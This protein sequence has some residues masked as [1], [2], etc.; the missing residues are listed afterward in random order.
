M[1]LAIILLNWRNEARTT[2]AAGEIMAWTAPRPELIVVDNES[3]ERSWATLQ[4]DLPDTE[5]VASSTNRGFAGGNNLGI[6]K[7]LEGDCDVVLLLNS[8]AAVTETAARALLD[9]LSAEPTISILSPAIL[10]T[11]RHKM[12]C[13]IGGRDIA[14]HSFTR[15]AVDPK[16]L[17]GVAGFPLHE[18]D[19]VSGTAFL[20][21]R[22]VFEEIGLLDE[23][24]FFSGEIADFCKRARQAGHRICV[25][26]TVEALHDTR[27][28]PAELRDTLYAYYS[29]RNRFLYIR[30][31]YWSNRR[32]YFLQW[33]KIGFREVARSVMVNNWARARAILFALFHGCSG[34]YGNQNANILPRD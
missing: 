30:K 20:A 1:K 7:A 21:R 27:Q 2:Q 26:L 13:L 5:L 9:R 18:V 23:D 8:D 32:R 6:R 19:F 33:L 15:I 4:N 25:D 17:T 34:I 14:R 28:T 22:R 10:E 11:D 3:N 31:H 12:I 29:L 16:A 24:F